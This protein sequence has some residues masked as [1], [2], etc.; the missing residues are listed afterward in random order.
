MVYEIW[1]HGFEFIIGTHFVITDCDF[2]C[3]LQIRRAASPE[4]NFDLDGEVGSDKAS[5]IQVIYPEGNN[6]D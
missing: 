1:M 6:L 5:E 3:I 2:T 4:I